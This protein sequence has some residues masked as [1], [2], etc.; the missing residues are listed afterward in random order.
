MRT[1][2]RSYY[3]AASWRGSGGGGKG[4][5]GVGRAVGHRWMLC[6]GALSAAADC[7]GSVRAALEGCPEMD[8][9]QKSGGD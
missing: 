5:Q 4:V 1:L 7:L 9:V 2:I 6:D 8:A 3:A